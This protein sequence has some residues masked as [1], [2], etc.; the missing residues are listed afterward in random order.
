MTRINQFVGDMD[1]VAYE[2]DEKTKAA[3]ER[4]IQIVTEAVA[5]LEMEGAEV[6]PEIEDTVEWATS[7]GILIIESLMK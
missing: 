5:R 1:F 7:C 3:V 4:K 2:R 6:Y